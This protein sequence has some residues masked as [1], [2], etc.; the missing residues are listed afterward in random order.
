MIAG[1]F[2]EYLTP[3][4]RRLRLISPLRGQQCQVALCKVPVYPWIHKTKP[5][6][7]PKSQDPPPTPLGLSQLSPVPVRSCLMEPQLGVLGI[8]GESL[9]A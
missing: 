5:L 4:A 8:E 9:D 1:A 2:D 7:A 3:N 6:R